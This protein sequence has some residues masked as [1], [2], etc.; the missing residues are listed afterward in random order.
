MQQRMK[1]Q[2]DKNR[3]ERVFAVGDQVFLRLQPYIQLLV[4]RR[5]NQKLSFKFFGPF[6]ILER[7]G[8][9][10]YRLELPASSKVHPV[11]HV[12]Q[13]KL[14]I[15]QNT[16]VSQ[17]LPSSD[18][19]FQVPESILQ[20][21]LCRRGRRTI[22]QALIKWSGGIAWGDLEPLRQHFPLAPAW[23]LA[24]F[25]EEGI[26]SDLDPSVSHTTRADQDTDSG[27]SPGRPKRTKKSP[28]WHRDG[29]WTV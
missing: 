26:V 24:G 29:N 5:I 16:Q 27:P 9:V 28:A 25:Q 15:G 11:F 20:Q 3:V 7:I 18:E 13:L 14:C 21:H 23:G 2:A 6:K 17:M 4:A 22:T 12:S 8:Q 1:D 19:L 10:A